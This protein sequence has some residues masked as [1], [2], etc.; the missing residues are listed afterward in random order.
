VHFVLALPILML[1]I[2]IAVLTSGTTLSPVI[3]IAP[4]L[5]LIQTL[6]IAGIAMAVASASVLFR[7]LRDLVAN[8]LQLGFFLTPVLYL[9][10]Q[11]PSAPMRAALRANPMTPFITSYQSVFFWGRPPETLDV[12]LMVVY[13]GLSLA[14]GT[15]VFDRLRDTLAEA[16]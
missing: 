7:D 11:I 1:A 13:A 16:I 15:V 8:L 12:V 6:F 14:F 2:V 3:L 4:L 5:M 10:D 9:L